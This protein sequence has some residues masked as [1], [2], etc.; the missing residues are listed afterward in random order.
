MDYEKTGGFI[1]GKRKEKG[2]T[3]KELASQLGVGDK[4]VSKSK[5]YG[6]FCCAGYVYCVYNKNCYSFIW[7]NHHFHKTGF[8]VRNAPADTGSPCSES[9]PSLFPRPSAPGNSFQPPHR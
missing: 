1:A 4:A 5:S 8:K 2:L 9:P 3:Q 7:G 6:K